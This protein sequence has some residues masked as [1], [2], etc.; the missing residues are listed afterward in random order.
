MP[1][2]PCPGAPPDAAAP[3]SAPPGSR[4]PPGEGSVVL[5]S[6]GLHRSTFGDGGLNCRVRNGTG[7]VPS[8][9]DA[10]LTGGLPRRARCTRY[11]ARGPSGA[12]TDARRHSFR[13][14][15]RLGRD[16]RYGK[17]RARTISTAR[18]RRSRALQL[19]P[20]DQVVYLGPYRK[21][22]SSWGRLRA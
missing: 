19:R 3:R 22:S 15:R 12:L 18:L 20:I 11:L 10:P 9:M 17:R 2:G 7:W 16:S 14:D 4:K 8:S 13:P 5:S 6:H 1:R 21:E